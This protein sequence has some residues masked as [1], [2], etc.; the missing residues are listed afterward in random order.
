MCHL[1]NDYANV[2]NFMKITS[3]LTQNRAENTKKADDKKL[4]FQKDQ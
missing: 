3:N 2:L 4:V 1:H